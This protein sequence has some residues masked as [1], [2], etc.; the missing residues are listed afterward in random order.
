[1]AWE[2]A[3]IVD[4]DC[5]ES[6]VDTLARYMPIWMVDTPQNKERALSVRKAVGEMWL[7]EAVCTTFTVKDLSAREYNSLSELSAVDLHHPKM[8]KLN[9]V[10]VDDSDS[11]RTGVNEFDFIP[12]MA[13]WPGT[14]AFRRPLDMLR[15]VPRLHLDASNWKKK[16][17]IYE[18]LFTVL[19]SPSWHGKSFSALNDSIV[20]GSINAVEIPYTLLIRNLKSANSEVR[21]FVFDLV[22]FISEREMEGC[23]V[24]IQIEADSK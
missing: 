22:T 13:T 10:G 20:T 4:P 1:M 11:L 21:A 6:A 2:I 5:S 15:N 3:V 23:P 17:D 24:S 8:A 7:P 18:S 19:G 12:A 16:D 14:I 9:F